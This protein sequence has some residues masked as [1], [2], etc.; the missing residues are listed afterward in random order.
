MKKFW[1]VYSIKKDIRISAQA[2]REF[3]EM[4][5][6]WLDRNQD[7]LE[8]G[9]TGDM[10][11]LMTLCGAWAVAYLDSFHAFR[12]STYIPHRLTVSHDD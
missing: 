2:R 11:E 3:E 6:A 10:R 9:G 7:V 4:F 5:S 1:M 8:E 12:V